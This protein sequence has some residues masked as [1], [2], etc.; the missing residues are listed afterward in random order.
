M[1]KKLVSF[2]SILLLVL[3]LQAGTVSA[4]VRTV[5]L[6]VKGMSCDGCA[7]AVEQ[8]LKSAEGVQT[9]QV[10][11]QRGRAVIKYDDQKITVARLREIITIAGYS[12]ESK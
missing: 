1:L 6:R 2:L 7:I 11:F 12:C 3:I 9:V 4:A 8:A 10:S 5:T